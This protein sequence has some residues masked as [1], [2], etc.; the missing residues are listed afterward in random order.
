M[1]WE[2][3]GRGGGAGRGGGGGCGGGVARAA[4]GGFLGGEAGEGVL[5]CLVSDFEGGTGEKEVWWGNGHTGDDD[6]Y[7]RGSST[8][9]GVILVGLVSRRARKDFA[10]AISVAAILAGGLRCAVR[11]DFAR[12]VD[13]GVP[14]GGC[15]RSREW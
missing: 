2:G 15:L 1:D 13:V 14:R 8:W 7:P 3:G 6:G 10:K 11:R 9:S 12:G 4:R 5:F